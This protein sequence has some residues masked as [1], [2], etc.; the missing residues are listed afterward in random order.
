MKDETLKAALRS[1]GVRP[2]M[3]SRVVEPVA[4]QPWHLLLPRFDLGV[5][6]L[7]RAKK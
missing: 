3:P 1:V 2:W 5:P 7:R 4:L 6:R